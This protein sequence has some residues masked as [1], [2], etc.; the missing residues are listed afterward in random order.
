MIDRVAARPGPPAV[1]VPVGFK[2]F[3]D[4]LST[5]RSVSA[6]RRAPARRSCG[7]TARCGRPTRTA[8]SPACSRPRS[9]RARGRDPGELYRELTERVRRAG[10]ERSTRR[11]ARAEGDRSRQL[12]PAAGARRTSSP[13]SRSTG[14]A[15]D[16]A[17]A[18]ARRSAGSRSST[19]N[20]WFAARP[21][22]TE[23]VYKIYA[24]SFRGEAHLERI[25]DEA[26]AHAGGPWHDTR[27]RTRT[28]TS[29]STSTSTT[30][31]NSIT[32]AAVEDER[33]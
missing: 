15:H 20:G 9:P 16:G 30:S 19:E 1:E 25:I 11:D 3:V 22:G 14:D 28:T 12:S 33:K 18:T 6:A 17:R 24:E 8:S 27:A 5:A 26:Q 31:T 29:T 10:Y 23:D 4:G 13:A 7:A 32:S 2:W 21:S